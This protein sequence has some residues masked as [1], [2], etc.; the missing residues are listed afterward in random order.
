MESVT[1]RLRLAEKT[2]MDDATILGQPTDVISQSTW[3]KK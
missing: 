2:E 1:K 3:E